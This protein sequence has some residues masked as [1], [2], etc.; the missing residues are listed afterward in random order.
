[1]KVA[2]LRW[3]IQDTRWRIQDTGYRIQDTRYKIQDDGYKMQGIKLVY[4]NPCAPEGVGG[5][6]D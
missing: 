6:G 5:R 3:R 1:M 4:L 2:A